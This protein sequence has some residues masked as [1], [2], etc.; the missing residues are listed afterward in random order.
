MDMTLTVSSAAVINLIVDKDIPSLNNY[1]QT[2][3][4]NLW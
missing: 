1:N 4:F 3:H 2:Q